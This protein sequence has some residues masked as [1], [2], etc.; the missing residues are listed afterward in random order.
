MYGIDK[1]YECSAG[2]AGYLPPY[3]HRVIASAMFAM[4]DPAILAVLHDKRISHGEW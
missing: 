4:E 3:A 1:D 2:A